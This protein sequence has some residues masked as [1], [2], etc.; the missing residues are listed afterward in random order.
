M[1]F[2]KAKRDLKA[3]YGYS[4]FESSDNECHKTLY[5]MFEVPGTSHPGAS[6]KLCAMRWQRSRFSQ[7]G[8]APQVVGDGDQL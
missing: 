1:E 7:G 2:Q 5:V 6:S 4:E 8:A 3:I